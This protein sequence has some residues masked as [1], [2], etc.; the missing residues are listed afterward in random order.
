LFANQEQ[1]MNAVDEQEGTQ[2]GTLPENQQVA[3]LIRAADLDDF[4]RQRGIPEARV[5]QC[6]SN[7]QELQRLA[8]MRQVGSDRYQI[9]GTPG[10]VINDELVRD[11][12]SWEA[13][14]PVLRERI[15]G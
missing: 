15:G 1:W 4:A 7:Q 11:V 6:A 5:N 10:F 2:I 14:E 8:E 3:A 12:T 9:P 13:L